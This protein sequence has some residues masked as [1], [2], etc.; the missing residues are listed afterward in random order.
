MRRR[1]RDLGLEPDAE[2]RVREVER[3][4]VNRPTESILAFDQDGRL[5]W[6][7]D[8]R[9]KASLKLTEADVAQLADRVVTHNHP[10]TL[11]VQ[12]DGEQYLQ[13]RVGGSLSPADVKV[14]IRRNVAEMRVVTRNVVDG[15]E[16]V[17]VYRLKRPP[18]G[19]PAGWKADDFVQ[20]VDRFS[21]A[22]RNILEARVQAGKARL[23][24]VSAQA[25]HEAWERRSPEYGVE[26]HAAVL[27]GA[28][29]R[30]RSRRRG[31]R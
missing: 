17:V 2:A 28:G 14:A 19:W 31:T 15:R 24:E 26:Y 21:T 16:R 9:G 27:E 5:A 23:C 3:D 13:Y 18:G 20:G 1:R 7:K 8:G 29:G 6:R 30:G 12:R 11:C 25:L 4:L 10:P 22:I